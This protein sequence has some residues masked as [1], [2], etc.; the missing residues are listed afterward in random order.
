MQFSSKHDAVQFLL[1][2]RYPRYARQIMN[3]QQVD[4]E[5]ELESGDAE[6]MRQFRKL[7]AN[8]P[9]AELRS[10]Y[11]KQWKQLQHEYY[12]HRI[13]CG[14]H[15][16]PEYSYWAAMPV[17]FLD[18]AAAL[19]ADVDPK[20]ASWETV[21]S[22]L[23]ASPFS[24]RFAKIREFLRRG[25][26]AGELDWPARPAKVLEWAEGRRLVIPSELAEAIRIYGG[27]RA[28]D[29]GL[30]TV[31]VQQQ[32]EIEQLQGRIRA[33]ESEAERL[34]DD[35]LKGR[36]RISC[37]RM[38]YGMAVAKFRFD[39]DAK[40][41]SA[42]SNIAGALHELGIDIDEDTVRKWLMESASAVG[43]MN[44]KPKSASD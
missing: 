30:N 19:I 32:N 9:E 18:E 28:T 10:E 1:A 6:G 13:Y 40:K 8:R 12:M 39:P 20:F 22:H 3:D 11:R 37:L 33:L 27:V 26:D 43:A 31:K 29:S 44:R 38:I 23:G 5:A 34:K 17:W 35:T 15:E 24:E 2:R 25:G 4:D 14:P 21:A 36:S 42:T 16:K 41:N 7:L